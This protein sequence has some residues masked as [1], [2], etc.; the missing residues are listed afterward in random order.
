[1]CASILSERLAS[2]CLRDS[3]YHTLLGTRTRILQALPIPVRKLK[4]TPKNGFMDSTG[5]TVLPWDMGWMPEAEKLG[6][7]VEP[8]I[9][10]GAGTGR[11]VSKGG[12]LQVPKVVAC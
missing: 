3:A 6:F 7:V 10:E 5:M 12:F 9:P 4:V 8:S 11:K 2:A 1:M